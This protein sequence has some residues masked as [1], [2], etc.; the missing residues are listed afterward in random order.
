MHGLS[1]E[2][3][4][5]C[6]MRNSPRSVSIGSASASR[7]TV[8][9]C[10]RRWN[11]RLAIRI[12]ARRSSE[13]GRICSR[14]SRYSCRRTTSPRCFA[15]CARSRPS[16]DCP[17]IE[18]RPCPGLRKSHATIT[19]RSACSW[20]T[21]SISP[22]DGPKLIEVNTNA[23]GAFLNALLA[24]AQR[25]CCAEVEAALTRSGSNDFDSA[26]LRMFQHEWIVAAKRRARR[27]GLRSSMIG[28]RSSI[29][30]RSSCWLSAFSRS[31]AS[32]PKSSM[33]GSFDTSTVSC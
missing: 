28:P 5:F 24:Q 22:A 25:A 29:S 27:A 18:T 16:R 13:R 10:A 33:P 7:S 14:M 19:G 21:T 17:A 20:A 15:S 2:F 3:L 31:M 8:T 9:R 23:G 12:S 1:T 11:G 4:C 26:V 32:N 30:T 6:R